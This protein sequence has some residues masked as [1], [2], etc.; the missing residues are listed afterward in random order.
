MDETYKGK[1]L[2]K[3]TKRTD[4]FKVKNLIVHKVDRPYKGQLL[5]KSTKWTD[6]VRVNFYIRPSNGWTKLRLK[7]W[8]VH[9]VDGHN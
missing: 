1:F 5:D 2:Y 7:I 9:K 8:G 3:S 6:P 4:L